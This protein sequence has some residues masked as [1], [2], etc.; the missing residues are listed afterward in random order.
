MTTS[1]MRAARF[2]EPGQALRIEE[3][4]IP[5]PR[6]HEVLVRVR[7]AGVCHTDIHIRSGQLPLVPGVELPLTLGHETAGEVAALGPD[8]EGV[9]EGDEVVVWGARGCGRCR[10]CH[11]GSES[12]CDQGTWLNGGYAEYA[13]I[14]GPRYL[15]SLGGVDPVQAAPLA[16]AG[17][18]PLH[19]I[20]K[21][22]PRLRAG[23]HVAL[24]GLGGLGHLAVQ[25]L[26]ALSPSTEIIAV[27]I[28]PS[29]RALA[30]KLGAR[31]AVDG[32][33]HPVE[34]IAEI[35]GGSGAAAVLDFVGSDDSLR[36]ALPSLGKAG[37][38]VI[39]GM[40]GGVLPISA[41]TLAPEASLTTSMWGSFPELEEVLA[42]AREGAIRCETS[43]F[44]LERLND[45]LDQLASG[46]V[47]GRAVVVP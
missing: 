20:R 11:S 42:L 38:L 29:K 18:T 30:L 46:E 6:G 5:E 19:A 27:D 41:F 14:P 9:R 17:L 31:H 3:I 10:L 35:T 32:L 37:I 26:R 24:F 47:L 25:I 4:P 39:V 45:V 8:V 23:D 21:A 13:L 7:A 22:L 40:A 28:E 34:R 2:Y 16:D 36:A 12:L 44:D 15:A 43:V 33:D 1:R